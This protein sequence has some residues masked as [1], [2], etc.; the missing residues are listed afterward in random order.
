M[1]SYI[2]FTRTV[3]GGNST[4]DF[5][6]D[7]DYY[8]LFGRGKRDP[9]EGRLSY[10]QGSTPSVSKNQFNPYQDSGDQGED[11]L[12]GRLVR[13]H[14]ILMLLAWPLLASTGIFLAAFMRPALPEGRWFQGH[15]ALM[16]ASLFVGAVGVVLAFVSQIHSSVPGLISLGV[17]EVSGWLASWVRVIY[18]NRDSKSN[19]G[20]GQQEC[21]VMYITLI[22]TETDASQNINLLIFS[23]HPTS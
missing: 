16:L 5:T 19:N 14:G 17:E 13:A 2:R 4:E 11:T 6:L 12:K 21:L 22:L 23:T 7:D 9:Q 3:N 18:W 1:Y 15:R 10:H 8:V 20:F